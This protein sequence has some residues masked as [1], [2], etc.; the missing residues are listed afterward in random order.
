MWNALPNE[1]AEKIRS[2]MKIDCPNQSANSISPFIKFNKQTIETSILVYIFVNIVGSFDIDLVLQVGFHIPNIFYWPKV[3]VRK[4]LLFG[5]KGLKC[6]PTKNGFNYTS[7]REKH[8]FWE[9]YTVRYGIIDIV[10]KCQNEMVSSIFDIPIRF[11]IQLT[12]RFFHR[13]RYELFYFTIKTP[14]KIHL[15][16]TL[17]FVADV[18]ILRTETERS[19]CFWHL[20]V[21]SVYLNRKWIRLWNAEFLQ[22]KCLNATIEMLTPISF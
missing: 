7:G 6:I 14:W 2:R 9:R 18:D 10:S 11:A 12:E 17:I 3:S 22:L 4:L 20:K 21:K 13:I 1:R 16:R 5:S 19:K 8:P 15:N